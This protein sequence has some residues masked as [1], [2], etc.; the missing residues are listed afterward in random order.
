MTSQLIENIQN[1]E[2][3]TYA[4]QELNNGF[5]PITY[6][7][8]HEKEEI[9]F[10]GIGEVDYLLWYDKKSREYYEKHVVQST[11]EPIDFSEMNEAA[12]TEISYYLRRGYRLI[13][14]DDVINPKSVLLYNFESYQEFLELNYDYTFL[15]LKSESFPI[16]KIQ[17][18]HRLM[19]KTKR[20]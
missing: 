10:Q 16:E 1:N 9:L 14:I 3:K 18:F 19:E 20:P 8:D 2:L 6:R 11:K 7:D 12:N 4:E 17:Q 5:T 15:R 13:S